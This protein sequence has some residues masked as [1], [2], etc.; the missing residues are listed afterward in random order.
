MLGIGSGEVQCIIGS[1]RESNHRKV[2]LPH[3]VS[4]KA[5]GIRDIGLGLKVVSVESLAQSFRTGNSVR[6]FA[7]IEVWGEGYETGSG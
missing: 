3:P 7:M 4:E 1:Q 2:S 5:C 6:N